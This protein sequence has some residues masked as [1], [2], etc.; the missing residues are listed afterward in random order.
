VL[1]RVLEATGLDA[2]ACARLLGI[3]PIT[4]GE[5]LANQRPIPE[6]YIVLL[7]DILGVESS[8]LRMPS[9]QAQRMGDLTPAIWYKFRGDKLTDADRECVVLI[10]LLGHFQ[11]EIED[12]TGRKA[13]GW[14]PLFEAIRQSVDA[15][16][17]PSEQGRRA[18]RF[19]RESAGLS[20]CATGIG[21]VFRG[22]LR[23]LGIL[24]IESPI[25]ES[26]VEGCSFYVGAHPMDRPCVFANS[27]HSTWF[28]RNVVLMH[29]VAH[30]IF[31]A[32]SSGASLDFV[33]SNEQTDLSEQRAEAFAQEAL[34]PR[35]VLNHLAQSLGIKWSDVSSE[36][37]AQLV[38]ETQVEQ[39]L[40]AR[41]A[42]AAG[43]APREIEASLLA[44][45][46]ADRLR[47]ISD[48]ALTTTEFL[49]KHGT[50][51]DKRRLMLGKRTTTIPSRPLLLPVPYVR[52]VIDAL[53]ERVIS[54]GRAA[55]LL[56]IDK[57]DLDSRFDEL[58]PA[59]AD[60]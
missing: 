14:K 36:D 5:W 7:A 11:N 48:R 27:Y 13:L 51:D 16:A 31:D 20:Q 56:M 8:V 40:V 19:F 33:D 24:I 22:N 26:T 12:V 59:M 41:A 1:D 2:Q 49:E 47:Q 37:M 32:S 43:F 10:R 58:V 44:L 42:V 3:S 53:K 30:A 6:S 34:V 21:N 39:K 28:R 25:Q 54:R 18:A 60:E 15:Q 4:F 55:E 9:K 38:A 45:E 57:Y 46:I 52:G 23:R 29:E 50:A 35:E 17:P